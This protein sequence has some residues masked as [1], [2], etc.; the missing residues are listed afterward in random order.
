MYTTEERTFLKE[1]FSE[2]TKGKD[3]T[4]KK[5]FLTQVFKND[6]VL[7]ASTVTHIHYDF[8]I[9]GTPVNTKLD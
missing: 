5:M 2:V 3:F 7:C 4:K 6:C 9:Y 1:K 8:R